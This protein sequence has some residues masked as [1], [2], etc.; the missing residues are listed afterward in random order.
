M[1]ISGDSYGGDLVSRRPVGYHRALGTTCGLDLKYVPPGTGV[2]DR[3]GRAFCGEACLNAS[4]HRHGQLWQ[5][6]HLVPDPRFHRKGDGWRRVK[7]WVRALL[8][9]DH[10]HRQH[11]RRDRRGQAKPR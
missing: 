11:P 3:G 7:H 5:P 4:R 8:P 9:A 2:Y 1:R 6:A 10:V